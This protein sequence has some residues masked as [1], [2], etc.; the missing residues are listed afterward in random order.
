[1]IIL[2]IWLQT[3][4][5][6]IS[7]TILP[8]RLLKVKLKRQ[9]SKKRLGWK[10]IREKIKQGHPIILE[11]VMFQEIENNYKENNLQEIRKKKDKTK[12]LQPK[13]ES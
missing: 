8:S 4:V 5:E 6:S 9:C 7:L 1:M 3:F 12:V 10:N 13:K 2:N 11:K